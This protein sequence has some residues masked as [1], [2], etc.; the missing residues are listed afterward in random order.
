MM[1]LNHHKISSVTVVLAAVAGVA[2]TYHNHKHNNATGSGHGVG[3]T[4]GEN[5]ALGVTIPISGIVIIFG[6]LWHFGCFTKVKGKYS[7]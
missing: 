6:L 4:T 5:I 1:A 3:F 2:A 7:I